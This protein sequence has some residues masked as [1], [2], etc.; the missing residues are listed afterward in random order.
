M[1][2]IVSLSALLISAALGG[3]L[4]S[5]ETDMACGFPAKSPGEPG[6]RIE[7]A[8]IQSLSQSPGA[9]SVRMSLNTGLKLSATAQRLG[10]RAMITGSIYDQVHYTIGLGANGYASLTIRDLARADAKVTREG[11]CRGHEKFL[12]RLTSQ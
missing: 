12:E 1:G 5:A 9:V 7:I 10:A 6:L 2:G 11:I 8:E 3:S 4:G